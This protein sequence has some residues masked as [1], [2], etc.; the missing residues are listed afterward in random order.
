L[1]D[2]GNIHTMRIVAT[3]DTHDIFPADFIPDGDV[4][5]HAGD[6]MW[7]GTPNEWNSRL[8]C[9]ARLPHKIKLFIAGNHDLHLQ[10]YGGAALQ[11][12]RQAGVTVVGEPAGRDIYTLP[13]GHRVLGLPFVHNLPRW[14]FNRTEEFLEDYMDHQRRV[15]IVVSH[16]PPSG[17]LDLN[18]GIRAYRKYLEKFEPDIWICG[19]IHEHGGESKQVG[20]TTVYNVAAMDRDYKLVT[21]P[22]IIDL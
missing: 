20:K 13:N 16:C 7:A 1:A 6:L 10:Y 19:H 21:P 2:I 12:L 3:S 18:Y 9:L 4:F 22:T 15:D 11:E 8:E 17:I 14:A 5:I